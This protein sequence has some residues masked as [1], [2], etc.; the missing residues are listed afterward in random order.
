MLGRLI[1]VANDWFSDLCSF[2]SHLK[3]CSILLWY[4]AHHMGEVQHFWLIFG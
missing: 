2:G 1:F 3:E 4:V